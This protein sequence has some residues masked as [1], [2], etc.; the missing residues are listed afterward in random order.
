[1]LVIQQLLT[2]PILDTVP[3][4]RN[5]KNSNLRH[6]SVREIHENRAATRYLVAKAWQAG[7]GYARPGA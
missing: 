6:G 4:D 5:A 7:K 3:L 1:M 2:L